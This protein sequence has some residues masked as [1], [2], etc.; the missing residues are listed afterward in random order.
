MRFVSLRR[1]IFCVFREYRKEDR[2]RFQT[3]RKSVHFTRKEKHPFLTETQLWKSNE[4][5]KLWFSVSLCSK[6]EIHFNNKWKGR[7]ILLYPQRMEW[8]SSHRKKKHCFIM[9]EHI[10]HPSG[11]GT[12]CLGLAFLKRLCF[13]HSGNGGDTLL[14]SNYC[15]PQVTPFSKNWRK[16]FFIPQK[17][18]WNLVN[19]RETWQFSSCLL[20][21]EIAFFL[22]T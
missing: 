18:R 1:P 22:L 10:S 15:F 12:I 4:V 17:Q 11:N 14:I 7:D 3:K 21:K 19:K 9:K 13:S 2:F 16:Y 5:P 6:I 20:R 8:I